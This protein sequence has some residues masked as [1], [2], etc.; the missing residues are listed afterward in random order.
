MRSLDSISGTKGKT[1]RST[2]TGETLLNA[3]AHID[4]M[5]LLMQLSD[6]T[7]REK[8]IHKVHRHSPALS[9]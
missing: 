5:L 6:H 9:F 3:N 2:K 8:I 4:S 1:K 7:L